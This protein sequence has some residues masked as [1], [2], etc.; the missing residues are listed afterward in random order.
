M[1]HSVK[2]TLKQELKIVR[3]YKAEGKAP[4]NIGIPF[5][6][7]AE[8]VWDILRKHGAVQESPTGYTDRRCEIGD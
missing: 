7:S 2:L 5:G 6:I 3:R 1:G 8:R 4:A